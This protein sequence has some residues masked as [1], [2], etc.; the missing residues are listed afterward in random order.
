MMSLITVHTGDQ[1]S[2]K[3]Q[4]IINST[5]HT[6]DTCPFTKFLTMV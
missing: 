4:N 6:E 1:G 2:L 3:S 5:T